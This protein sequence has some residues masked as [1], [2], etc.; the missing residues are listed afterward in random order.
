VE[1]IILNEISKIKKPNNAYPHSFIDPSH[2][3]MRRRRRRKRK[4]KNR[5]RRRTWDTM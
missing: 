5:R 1:S 3:T 4:K 2:K